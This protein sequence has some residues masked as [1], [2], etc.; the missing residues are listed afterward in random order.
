MKT[1]VTTI[2][3]CNDCPHKQHT[4]AFTHGGSKPC[5]DHPKIIE[6]KG[7]DC[8]KR[9]IPYKKVFSDVA[10]RDLACVKRIPDWCPL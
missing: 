6:A 1:I 7:Y 4:G 5:C 9:I 2:N 3:T 10:G 8:F